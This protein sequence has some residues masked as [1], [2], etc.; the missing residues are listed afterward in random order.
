EPFKLKL[1]MECQEFHKRQ[2]RHFLDNLL[3]NTPEAGFTLSNVTNLEEHEQQIIKDYFDKAVYPMLT[4]MVF[5]GYHTFP[6]LMNKLLIFGVV[7]IT[8]GDKK[9]NRKLSFVQVPSNI[10]R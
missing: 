10:P 6:I 3:P 2:Q 9:D 7:T 5:D 8:P 1:M 4:P